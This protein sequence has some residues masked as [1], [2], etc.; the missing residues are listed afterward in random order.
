MLRRGYSTSSPIW[1]SLFFGRGRRRFSDLIRI[2]LDISS[3][4][5]K[6]NAGSRILRD[7]GLAQRYMSVLQVGA[8]CNTLKKHVCEGILCTHQ[9]PLRL[10]WIFYLNGVSSK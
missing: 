2:A 7:G 1:E 4:L 9:S 6:L 3:I 10:P 5:S 8:P